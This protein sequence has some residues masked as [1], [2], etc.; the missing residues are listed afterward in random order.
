MLRWMQVTLVFAIEKLS[1][2]SSLS[3]ESDW[4]KELVSNPKRLQRVI[5][6]LAKIPR[7]MMRTEHL[8]RAEEGRDSR[9]NSLLQSVHI[10]EETS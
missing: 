5:L 2:Y 6:K 8:K 9:W 4:R 7:N 1:N 3:T 10:D